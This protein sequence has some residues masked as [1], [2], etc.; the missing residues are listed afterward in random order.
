MIALDAKKREATITSQA[1][2]QEVLGKT[3]TGEVKAS[4]T[5]TAETKTIAGISCKVHNVSVEVPFSMGG[6][7]MQMALVMAGPACLSKDAPG[8]AD[9]AAALHDRRPRRASSSATR[10]ARRAPARRWP[11]AWRTS[12]RRWPRPASPSTRTCTPS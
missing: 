5:P 6:P 8:Y 3:S 9:Y 2:L 4:V 7:E 10:A 1:K 12:R 11:R